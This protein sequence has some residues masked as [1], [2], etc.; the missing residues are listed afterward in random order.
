MHKH[1]SEMEIWKS[2]FVLK[3][4]IVAAIICLSGFAHADLGLVN[5]DSGL[6]FRVTPNGRRITALPSGYHVDIIGHWGRWTRV[7]I[8]N[9]QIGYVYSKYITPFKK[10]RSYL[11]PVA[12][13]PVHFLRPN[14]FVQ[15]SRLPNP[16]PLLSLYHIQSRPTEQ[17][18]EAAFCPQCQAYRRT[19]SLGRLRR[20]SREIHRVA[21]AAIPRDTKSAPIMAPF[22]RALHQCAPGCSYRSLGIWGD[23]RHQHER[24]CHNSGSAVDVGG[25]ICHGRVYAANYNAGSSTRFGRFVSCLRRHRNLYVIYGHGGRGNHMRH[26][27]VSLRSCEHNGI[28]KIRT[29]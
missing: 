23:A 9:G 8:A 19:R 26:A 18:T 10:P 27:H 20:Q 4:M 5:A 15:S 17:A 14:A 2:N 7:R 22:L 29:R 3:V 12:G 11:L 21:A 13:H 1:L 16:P 24:S 6:N 25:L 28:G